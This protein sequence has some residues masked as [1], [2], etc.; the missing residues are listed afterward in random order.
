MTIRKGLL[1][2]IFFDPSLHEKRPNHET[3]SYRHCEEW[4]NLQRH[5]NLGLSDTDGDLIEK[6]N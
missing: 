6:L 1:F 3:I 2:R 4:N 5:S